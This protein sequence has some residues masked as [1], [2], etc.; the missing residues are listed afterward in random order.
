VGAVAARNQTYAYSSGQLAEIDGLAIL[1]YHDNGMVSQVQHENDVTDFIDKDP[2]QMMRPSNIRF[3][4]PV[5]VGQPA[6]LGV[7]SYDGGG[8]LFRL[9][10]EPGA[11]TFQQLGPDAAPAQLPQAADTY[12]LYDTLGRI[13]LHHDQAGTEQP[14]AYDTLGNATQ[15]GSAAYTVSKAT[16]R[17]TM[18]SYD[19]RGNM[20]S[21]T[22]VPNPSEVYSWDL[23]DQLAARNFPYETHLYTVDGE[24][25]WTLHQSPEGLSEKFTLRDLGGKVLSLYEKASGITSW[26]HDYLHRGN[27]SLGK[28]TPE[29]APNDRV[30]FTLD[31][32]GSTRVVTRD[33]GTTLETHHFF[34]Y[35]EQFSGNRKSEEK[36]LFTGHER[37]KNG[38]GAVDDL[39]YMHARY[40]GPQLGR[41]L[42]A[43]IVE[44]K[45]HA[46]QSWNRYSY[47]MGNPLNYVDP[48]GLDGINAMDVMSAIGEAL[49]QTVDDAAYTVAYPMLKMGSGIL[50]DDPIEFASGVGL[51]GVDAATM[52]GGKIASEAL[53]FG[54]TSS[55]N[56]VT[57]F[58]K[59]GA[60]MGFRT[61][62]GYAHAAAKFAGTFGKE[63]VQTLMTRNGE[64]ML[65]NRLY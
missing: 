47:V 63:G 51:I 61:A 12:F 16:N 56:I 42:S 55:R 39:D 22:N 46:P 26:K 36:L 19:P 43:D 27:L 2:H 24:R 59:H 48:N 62:E 13:K 14:Y 35:G 20:T 60:E 54:W 6:Q 25:V 41:F 18:A 49:V 57:H 23:V 40:Y 29:P 21:R 3:V 30:H 58:R 50:N 10:P 64:R 31:H 1:A 8:N 5:T 53:Q 17:L 52:A 65:Y 7:H 11:L 15:I 38:T 4:P 32:L 9:R 28:T 44:G 45:L 33:N 34:A 37:D